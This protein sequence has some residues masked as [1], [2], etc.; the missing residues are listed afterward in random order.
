MKN[1]ISLLALA[2]L[3]LSPQAFAKKSGRSLASAS[4]T[5]EQ[6][7]WDAAL[8]LEN[9]SFGKGSAVK[10]STVA[11]LNEVTNTYRY[12]VHVVNDS[13]KNVG[14]FDYYIWITKV[15]STKNCLISNVSD[16]DDREQG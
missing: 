9:L 14:D 4:G 12:R 11:V 16:Q 1:L 6:S 15:P 3:L 13:G 10:A 5:C 2:V 8:F 7:A